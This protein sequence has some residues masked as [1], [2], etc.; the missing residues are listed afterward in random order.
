MIHVGIDLH[1]KYSEICELDDDGA[2]LERCRLS[3]T[4]ASFQAVVQ[5]A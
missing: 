2:I 4:E 1:Q 5:G 3:T